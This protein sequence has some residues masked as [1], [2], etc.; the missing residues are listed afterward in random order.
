MPILTTSPSMVSVSAQAL[1]RWNAE[2]RIIAAMIRIFWIGM[3]SSLK[4]DSILG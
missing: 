3:I 2:N 4:D 1:A